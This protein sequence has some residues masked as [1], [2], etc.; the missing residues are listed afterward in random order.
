M[1]IEGPGKPIHS[2]LAG[3]PDVDERIETFVVGLGEA[4]DQCQD[5]EAQAD[6]AGLGQRARQLA[7]DARELGYEPLAEC[8]ERMSVA[9]GEANPEAVYKAV[10]DLTDVAQ[11][12]RRGHRTC[13]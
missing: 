13:A 7:A 6:Y 12:V 10:A 11:R 2:A 5:L 3:D 8:V 4:V 9:C 1:A